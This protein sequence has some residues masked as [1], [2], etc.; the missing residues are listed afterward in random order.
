MRLS[1]LLLFLLSANLIYA[2]ELVPFRDKKLWGYADQAGKIIIEPQYEKCFPFQ[3]NGL[4]QVL[5]EGLYFLINKSNEVKSVAQDSEIANVNEEIDSK[6]LIQKKEALKKAELKKEAE[7]VKSAYVIKTNSGDFI[8]S[9]DLTAIETGIYI[10]D[11]IDTTKKNKFGVI[12]EKNQILIPFEYDFISTQISEGLIVVA[13]ENRYG[14]C[15]MKGNAIIKCSYA[16]ADPFQNGIARVYLSRN[17]YSTNSTGYINKAGIEFFKSDPI[18]QITYKENKYIATDQYFNAV[19]IAD[20]DY[21][22]IRIVNKIYFLTSKNKSAKLYDSDGKLLIEGT[23]MT[24]LTNNTVLLTQKNYQK[25]FNFTTKQTIVD[26][27]DHITSKIT[28]PVSL[29]LFGYTYLNHEK[30]FGLITMT[31]KSL[32]QPKYE[33]I[34]FTGAYFIVKNSKYQFAI[35]D[36]SNKLI[37]PFSYDIITYLSKNLFCIQSAGVTEIYDARTNSKTNLKIKVKK[38][39]YTIMA[40]VFENDKGLK[41]YI[42]S[43]TEEIL[44]P[45]YKAAAT[46]KMFDKNFFPID[47]VRFTRNDLKYDVYNIQTGKVI[48]SG[49]EAIASAQ[50]NML[51]VKFDN[52]YYFYNNLGTKMFDT[53]YEQIQTVNSEGFAAA[54]LNSKWG[55][56]DRENNAVLDFKYQHITNMVDY[57][58][59]YMDKGN[60]GIMDIND[61]VLIQPQYQSLEYI[62]TQINDT[63]PTTYYFLAELND[64]KGIINQKNEVISPFELEGLSDFPFSSE[65]FIMRRNQKPMLFNSQGKVLID[66]K[67]DEIFPVEIY[68]PNGN[69]FAQVLKG[70]KYGLYQID[71]K[72]ILDCSY[73][74]INEFSD[75]YDSQQ[76]MYFTVEKNGKTGLV[77]NT[78]EIILEANYNKLEN[79]FGDEVS[80]QL[81]KS[82]GK[83]GLYKD[84]R[85]KITDCLYDEI[86]FNDESVYSSEFIVKMNGKYGLLDTTGKLVANTVYN[87]ISKFEY[88]NDEVM[89]EILQ[90]SKKGLMKKDGKIIIPPLFDKIEP[91]Y[92]IDNLGFY[93][94]K[95]KLIGVYGHDGKEL[96]ECKFVKTEYSDD[97]RYS[98]FFI[99]KEK[100]YWGIT[101][102]L[103]V[104]KLNR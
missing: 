76:R 21:D 55:I 4:A 94:Y 1:V 71:G 5:K 30:K 73:D 18:Y 72:L 81:I 38:S 75:F 14:Y 93:T 58:V 9:G 41:G 48:I 51:P 70:K 36:T 90:N 50:G 47:L 99:T 78:G 2:Q 19:P 45:I 104:E 82:N 11:I 102:D 85:I 49:C 100:E 7:I 3:K 67:Y 103:I 74:K 69:Q 52:K 22:E 57:L 6:E 35:C 37:V 28:D 97:D 98:M 86:L 64:K 53:G 66:D 15:D 46:V 62:S 89:Y 61:T 29:K 27:M 92:D 87:K 91:I 59:L 40:G 34:Q 10:A 65:V 96:L 83:F 56:I 32:L 80:F 84:Y 16:M 23:T 88:D 42:N 26:S 20:M 77:C 44:N 60:Y 24:L 79:Y 39:Q 54:K 17:D 63:L 33:S 31:D 95:N 12:N 25:I 13:K 8:S 68:D 101:Y 43:T